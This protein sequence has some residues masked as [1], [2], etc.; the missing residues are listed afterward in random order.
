MTQE[1]H[2]KPT[3]RRL[4]QF[5]RDVGALEVES[6]TLE[7]P[8]FGKRGSTLIQIVSTDISGGVYPLEIEVEVALVPGQWISYGTYDVS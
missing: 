1:T 5:G 4:P 3:S 7:P 2:G 6:I 8:A